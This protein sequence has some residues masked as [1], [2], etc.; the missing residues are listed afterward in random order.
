MAI[1]QFLE[2]L[3][4]PAITSLLVVFLLA[5]FMVTSVDSGALVVDNLAAGGKEDTPVP[6]RVLWVGLIGLVAMVL[7]ALGGDTALKG[8]QAGAIAMGLPFL[9]LMLVLMVG[10]VKSLIQDVRS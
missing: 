6:Q 7:F 2:V 9:M 10:F 1:F 4:F 8:V 3:P 5:V